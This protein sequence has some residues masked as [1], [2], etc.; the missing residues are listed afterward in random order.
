[1]S[2]CD[3]GDC[4]GFG[5]CRHGN[6]ARR[7]QLISCS[8]RSGPQ[9]LADT[10]VATCPL[11]SSGPVLRPALLACQ[12]PGIMHSDS[13]HRAL[14]KGHDPR[15]DPGG[16]Q[17]SPYRRGHRGTHFVMAKA[18]DSRGLDCPGVRSAGPVGRLGR[19]GMAIAAGTRHK[20]ERGRLRRRGKVSAGGGQAIP[21]SRQS[22]ARYSRGQS[23][24]PGYAEFRRS[25]WFPGKVKPFRRTYSGIST[26][27]SRSAIRGSGKRRAEACSYWSE[28]RFPGRRGP[29]ARRFARF[30]LIG[31]LSLPGFRG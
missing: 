21:Q 26:K 7:D 12:A 1:M 6:P 25:G 9:R 18:S 30:C 28:R 31:Q 23:G 4:R 24:H 22:R 11:L 14:P 16:G 3:P 29:R 5:R 20:A 13:T 2:S 10:R 27:L 8:V 17:R 19:P 15:R